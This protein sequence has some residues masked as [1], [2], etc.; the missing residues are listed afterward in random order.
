MS[1]SSVILCAGDLHNVGDFALLGQ[2]VE[3]VRRHLPG[4]PIH[5]RQWSRLDGSVTDQLEQL[6]VSVLQGKA[7]GKCLLAARRALILVAG[8]QMVRDN[9]SFASIAFLSMMMR[10]ARLTR[11]A[12]AVLACGVSELK[13]PSLRRLWRGMLKRS[14]ALSTRDSTSQQR[15]SEIAGPT[16]EVR[17]SADLAFLP[18][19]LH[20]AL[21]SG[22]GRD[23]LVIAPCQDASEGRSVN[24]G[25]LAAVALGLVRAAG[26]TR[27]VI[28]AHDS[29]P[30]M[31]PPVC[32]AVFETLAETDTEV[33]MLKSFVLSDFTA[34]YARAGIVVTNRLHAV[35]FGLIA[36]AT[37]VVLN[38]GGAK[39]LDAARVYSL[40]VLTGDVTSD[41]LV[42]SIAAE[43]RAGWPAAR[44][45]AFEAASSTVADDV[46]R[47]AL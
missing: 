7:L 4:T 23:T 24:A 39:T 21:R 15:M 6:G 25:H 47:L 37:P 19:R 11:G 29:R 32:Q 5:V 33:V 27:I 12:T 26:L 3:A 10:T 36:G 28:A 44:V 46:A 22:A 17:L 20:T 43:T 30:T 35:I 41:A 16:A 34:V 45:K 42:E 31:D 2:A 14:K 18:T 13:K 40:P 8:G 38:D 1:Y 9:A